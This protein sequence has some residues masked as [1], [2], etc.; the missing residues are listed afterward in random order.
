MVTLNSLLAT[1][2]SGGRQLPIT[3]HA[4]LQLGG[5]FSMVR[6][7]FRQQRG[8]PPAGRSQKECFEVGDAIERSMHE[9][10]SR[11]GR[12]PRAREPSHVEPVDA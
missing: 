4:R 8:A 10:H 1:S 11:A 6:V 5:Q 7:E 2:Q 3:R 9:Q 12:T